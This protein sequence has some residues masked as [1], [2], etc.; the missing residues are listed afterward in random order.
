LNKYV[1]DNEAKGF[2]VDTQR[3]AKLINPFTI[4]DALNKPLLKP[5]GKKD[6]SGELFMKAHKA[7]ALCTLVKKWYEIEHAPKTVKLRDF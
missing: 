4:E 6:L 1:K 5:V 7:T 3:M 2:E